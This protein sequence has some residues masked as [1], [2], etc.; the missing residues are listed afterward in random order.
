MISCPSS[1]NYLKWF[2][3]FNTTRLL[4][5]HKKLAAWLVS[6]CDTISQRDTL[7]KT[8][9][10][11][12]P[13]DVFGKCSKN[14][15]PETKDL[16]CRDYMGQN[17]K[18]YLAFENSLCVDY[19]TEKF[20]LAYQ[21]NM[22]PVTFGW[23]NYSLYGPPGSYI[24]AL[25]Y[26]SIEDLANYLLYLDKNDDEYLKYFDWRGKYDVHFLKVEE[27]LCTTCKV[28]K[29]HMDKR[30]SNT[31]SGDLMQQA[32]QRTRYPSFR[33]WQESL[34]SGQSTAAFHVGEHLVINSQKG[35]INPS[36]HP[37]FQR[38]IDGD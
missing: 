38:W 23:V 22:V 30:R 20:F 37:N 15:C 27:H 24:N 29:D 9:Q 33:K 8:L 1:I 31:T 36:E 5:S 25:D 11:Y 28:M 14:K 3:S 21:Y 7:A 17:Y 6:H 4:F 32:T 12:I 26:D 35:C 2:K 13:V 19:V 18:F 34:P 16:S 10:R